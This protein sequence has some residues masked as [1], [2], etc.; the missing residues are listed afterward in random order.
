MAVE[1][2]QDF[3]YGGFLLLIG[4][5]L[6]SKI[7]ILQ[8]LYIPASV[9]G[10]V[11]GLL[12][13]NQVLGKICPFSFNFSA[14][15]SALA[16]PLLAIVFC[17]QLIDAK[18]DKRMIKSGLSVGL[19]NSGTACLQNAVCGVVM[20]V[21]IAVGASKAPI[22][23]STM[24]FTGFYGGHGV[25]AI[26]ANIFEG[27]G[28]WDASSA[29]SVGT[30]F[31]TVGLLFGVVIGIVV[32]NIAARKGIIAA[33]AG[34]QNLTEEEKSGYIP[35]EKRTGA[36]DAVTTNDAINPLA[37]QLAIIFS[38]MFFAYKLLLVPGFSKFGI[39]ICCLFVSI[40]YTVLGKFTPVGKYFDRKSLLNTSGAALEYLIVSSVAMTNLKVFADYGLE[41]IVLSVVCAL[42]TLVYVFFFGKRWH[43][44]NWVENSLGTFG[45]AN[46]VL[47]TGFLLIRVADPDG[48]TDAT[49]NLALGNSLSTTTVQ[50]F[51]LLVYPTML[52]K[53]PAS[54]I[55]LAV[56]GLIVFTA[57][58]CIL[59]MKRK[60]S[61]NQ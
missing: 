11:V 30:T 13:G 2:V 52:A 37:F 17:T 20:L 48:K 19:L 21:L 22:G 56:G 45:L 36:V 41:L 7:K 29:T 44:K 1:I 57:A 10:G 54:A 18:F 28:H 60:A 39:T 6:R 34:I 51:F 3:A 33:N 5:I 46:G 14:N 8:K 27:L 23:M 32:I 31:A 12:L 55:T 40:V 49:L 38:I 16:M 47:A 35:P 61:A 25:P 26:A 59:N 50:M 4:Y 24:P 9:I 43:K 53:N 42:T 15:M 58:G